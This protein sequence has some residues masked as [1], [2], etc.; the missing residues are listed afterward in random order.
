MNPARALIEL[1]AHPRKWLESHFLMAFAGVP[2]T[3]GVQTHYF[4]NT[5]L[6]GTQ[7]GNV[8]QRTTG[9]QANYL[10]TKGKGT[11][12]FTFHPSTM[13]VQF[14]PSVVQHPV[15]NVPVVGSATLNN[16]FAGLPLNNLGG[17]QGA[18]FMVTTMLNGCT[19]VI[20]GAG[21]S[22]L[23][24]QPTGGATSAHVR[25]SLAP[26]YAA[27]FGGGGN[28]Y[29]HTIQDATIIGV[30]KQGAWKIYAQVHTRAGKD[31][32]RVEKIFG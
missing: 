16:G 25:N 14:T 7:G 30:L 24:V 28:E 17:V 21:P 26:H 12:T 5:D 15:I 19:F 22:V 4:G 20:D 29:D 31:I 1:R 10:V 27:V 11:R 13:Q 8:P 6:S 9:S 23:H 32:L 2:K 3:F 18:H